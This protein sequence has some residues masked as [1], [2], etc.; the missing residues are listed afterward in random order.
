MRVSLDS[1]K[2]SF[3]SVNRH[4]VSICFGGVLLEIWMKGIV[5]FYCHFLIIFLSFQYFTKHFLNLLIIV[6]MFLFIFD[7]LWSRGQG[8]CSPPYWFVWPQC[9]SVMTCLTCVSKSN[10]H[11]A[12][13]TMMQRCLKDQKSVPILSLLHCLLLLKFLECLCILWLQ[14]GEIYKFFPSFL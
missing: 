1:I 13:L 7:C 2:L 6:W 5:L 9:S 3:S 4:L 8:T 11:V 10:I 12:A 14:R